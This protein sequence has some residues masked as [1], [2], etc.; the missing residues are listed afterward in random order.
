MTP[1]ENNESSLIKPIK[2]T[3][4][5]FTF[6]LLLTYGYFLS[7]KIRDRRS[8]LDRISSLNTKYNEQSST[9]QQ[10]LSHSHLP[11][12]NSTHL[13]S[14][15][16][17]DDKYFRLARLLPCRTVEYTGGPKIDAIH[18]CDYSSS[19]EFSIQNTIQ[20]QKWLYEH[21]HPSNCSNKRFAIIQNFAPSGFGST[22]H[23][24]VWAFGMALADDR[25]AIY[26]TPGNWVR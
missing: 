10:Q 4:I 6:V 20:A 18:S 3:F 24:I 23:Q 25:I 21:Q 1:I 7:L 19:N 16:F 14:I 5:L 12:S 13:W 9:N 8:K 11:T 2:I 22:V 15:R 17:A 26:K